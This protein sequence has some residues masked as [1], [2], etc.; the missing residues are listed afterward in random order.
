[1]SSFTAAGIATLDAAGCFVDA[2][3][4]ALEILGRPRDAVVGHHATEFM[5]QPP[6]AHEREALDAEWQRAG[7]PDVEGAASLRRADGSVVRVRFLITP[8]DGGGS[9]A[10]IEP[11]GQTVVTATTIRTVGDV[12]T[13]WRA[14]ERR[15]EVV[16]PGSDEAATINAEVEALRA[17][18]H[19]LVDGRRRGG[20]AG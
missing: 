18:Y 17:R 14:A 6:T 1:M 7:S 13:Q 19:E 3:E 5:V 8:R 4:A 9:T 2:D 11:L 12:L 10:I 15:L 16:E 20:R